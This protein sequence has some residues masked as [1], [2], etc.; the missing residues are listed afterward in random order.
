[1]NR[2]RI[3]RAKKKPPGRSWRLEPL[4]DAKHLSSRRPP[5]AK[6]RK[7][8]KAESAQNLPASQ[9]YLQ[10]PAVGMDICH[11]VAHGFTILDRMLSVNV[12]FGKLIHTKC[13]P[14]HPGE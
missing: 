11:Y 2:G 10:R 7:V 13:D 3:I 9:A 12:C 4:L 14:A 6:Q 5:A 8:G 1:M